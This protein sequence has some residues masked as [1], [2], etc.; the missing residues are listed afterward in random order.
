MMGRRLQHLLRNEK[1][2]L[3]RNLPL[4]LSL[5]SSSVSMLMK[6]APLEYFSY[7][8]NR[9]H[10]DDRREEES[11]ARLAGDSSPAAQNDGMMPGLHLSRKSSKLVTARSS[12]LF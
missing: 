11:Q 3:R 12:N 2:N 5:H 7:R 6:C 8:Y 4:L 9:R 1:R 10:S